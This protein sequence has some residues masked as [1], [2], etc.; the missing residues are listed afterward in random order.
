MDSSEQ[1]SARAGRSSGTRGT[2]TCSSMATAGAGQGS[3][4][5]PTSGASTGTPSSP[6][7]S[8]LA[9]SPASRS[10]SRDGSA[11]RQMSGGSGLSTREPFATF[12]PDERSW[13]TSQGSL[14]LTEALA[15][16]SASWP[17][18]GMTRSGRA[19]RRAHL[20]PRTTATVFGSLPTPNLDTP[21]ANDS[22]GGRKSSH[23]RPSGLQSAAHSMQAG[24]LPGGLWP[25]ATTDSASERPGR[26]AQGGLPLTVAVREAS[27]PTPGAQDAKWRSTPAQAEQRKGRRQSS[28]HDVVIRREMLPTPMSS[29]GNRGATATDR[30]GHTANLA[31]TVRASTE[32]PAT[33]HGSPSLWP[34][35]RASE[36]KGTGPIGSSSHQHR[37]SRGYL[38]ATVQDREQSS[39]PLNPAW[40]EW[41]MG[42]PAGAT[43]CGHSAT[44]SCPKSRR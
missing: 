38:D 9:G 39:G 31:D 14:G 33:P 11:H 44:A 41:L 15:T 3:P 16:Y 21:T 5:T 40:V 26:Y 2:S 18:S 4:A 32:Q 23:G 29:A 1:G 30:T 17:R 42:W 36:W 10:V 8:S 13:K 12:D 28:L 20:A 37:V 24:P 35:P 22:R 25:T 27:F 7:T 6:S 34:T 43:D 19:F